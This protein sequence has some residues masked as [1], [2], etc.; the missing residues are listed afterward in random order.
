[1]SEPQYLRIPVDADVRTG[2]TVPIEDKDGTQTGE[3]T[4]KSA[5]R[6][7]NRRSECWRYQITATIA[8]RRYYGTCDGAGEYVHVRP[9]KHQAEP[10]TE[11]AEVLVADIRRIRE[12]LDARDLAE[13]P[14]TCCTR[15]PRVA[16][17]DAG[18]A[19]VSPRPG[20]EPRHFDESA[21]QLTMF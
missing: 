12:R 5:R 3:A 10:E 14:R 4:I 18:P 11:N 8:G 19:Y 13:L 2:N 9:Y 7:A 21:A 6:V 17:T 20:P 1:M 16:M 15:T